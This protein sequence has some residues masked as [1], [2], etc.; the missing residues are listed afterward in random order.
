M[1]CICLMCS[2]SLSTKDCTSSILSPSMTTHCCRFSCMDQENWVTYVPH[3]GWCKWREFCQSHA[4]LMCI[5]LHVVVLDKEALFRMA[6][7][8]KSC[9][10]DV[11][12]S[13]INQVDQLTGFSLHLGYLETWQRQKCVWGTRNV[14]LFR[15][16]T[17][18]S[19]LI[20][21]CDHSFS[22]EE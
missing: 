6:I 1:L 7:Y 5:L 13:S 3:Y 21:N 20:F 8:D 18:G 9:T 2:L 22:V 15:V 14:L 10:H 12:C 4:M 17:L 16:L 11:T 19:S